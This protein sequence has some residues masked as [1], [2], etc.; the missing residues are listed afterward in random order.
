MDVQA[1]LAKLADPAYRTFQVKLVPTVDPARILG[2]RMPALRAF[3]RTLWRTRPDDARAFLNGPLPHET[4]DEMN[5]HGA[6][7]GLAARTPSEAFG[8]LERFLPHVDNWA[9]SD[10]IKVPAFKR[11][12][13]TVAERLHAWMQATGPQTEYVVRFAVT[14]LMELYLGDAFEPEQLQWVAAIDRPEYYINMARAWYFSYALIKQPEA[15]LPLFE[16]RDAQGQPQLDPW[17]HNK[18][19]QKARESRRISADQKA[20][21]QTLKV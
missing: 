11:D 10:L 13:P 6:L 18:S 5:L 20:Y 17:T 19:L 7:I 14:Q 9:T 12:L 1:E 21:L 4:Y 15:A 3:A 16:R 8:L 2:V